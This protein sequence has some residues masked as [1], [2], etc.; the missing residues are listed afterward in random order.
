MKDKIKEFRDKNPLLDFF[1]AFVPVIGEAQDVQDFAHAAKDKNFGGMALA[2]M[3]LLIPG[4]TGGQFR[5]LAKFGDDAIGGGIKKIMNEVLPDTLKS[6]G[7]KTASDGAFVNPQ[8]RRFIRYDGKLTAEDSIKDIID[9]KK[10]QVRQTAEREALKKQTKTLKKLEDMGFKEFNPKLWFAGRHDVS[11]EDIKTFTSHFDEYLDIAKKV[12]DKT[13][14]ERSD[15]WYGLFGSTWKKVSPEDY[16]V[17]LSSSFKKSGL[18]WDGITRYNALRREAYNAMK[19][20][21][22]V[23]NWTT[24]NG[25]QGAIFAVERNNGPLL[26]NIVGK[27]SKHAHR[28]LDKSQAYQE[29]NSKLPGVTEFNGAIEY[30]TN[31]ATGGKHKGLWK[32]FGSDMRVKAIRGNNG[33]FDMS[34]AHPYLGIIPPVIGLITYNK[35]VKNNSDKQYN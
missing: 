26:R 3:G 23:A 4:L 10:R 34:R 9:S 25:A 13:L 5:K 18:E 24:T 27:D 11:A 33:N 31:P 7:W 20:G 1:A 17:S 30:G 12:K 14:V 21:E 8:G 29:L 32:I 2:S 22:D 6:K 16:I 28:T 35:Y 19:S 15:G